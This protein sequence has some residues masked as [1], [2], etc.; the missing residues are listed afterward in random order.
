LLILGLFNRLKK[1]LEFEAGCE[2]IYQ[3]EDVIDF[4]RFF[5]SL[6]VRTRRWKGLGSSSA[7]L[8]GNF[9]TEF[10]NLINAAG[11]ALP[12]PSAQR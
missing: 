2:L 6:E 1:I 11:L 8:E 4:Y 5:G 12:S 7:F 3:S 9:L 10:C